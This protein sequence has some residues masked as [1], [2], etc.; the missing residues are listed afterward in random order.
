MQGL[1]SPASQPSTTG[2][3]VSRVQVVGGRNCGPANLLRLG[4][5]TP[6]KRANLR[7][8]CGRYGGMGRSNTLRFD[9]SGASRAVS[10][11]Q[12]SAQGW[13]NTRLLAPQI[14]VLTRCQTAGESAQQ[15][16]NCSTTTPART[17][18]SNARCRFRTSDILLVRQALYR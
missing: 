8:G 12:A 2:R 17:P 6:G 18:S 3:Q 7:R 13:Q 15:W 9:G 4:R 16:S 1:D 5:I 14:G 11:I 10:R